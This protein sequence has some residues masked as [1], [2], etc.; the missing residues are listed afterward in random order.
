MTDKRAVACNVNVKLLTL[1]LQ[2]YLADN[3]DVFPPG[4]RW[5][6]L[7]AGY[8]EGASRFTCPEAHNRVCSY[9]FNRALSG[10]A[11]PA[12]AD[13][14]EVIAIFES[15]AGWNAFGGPELL[16]SEPRHF[17]GEYVG[18]VSSAA[19]WKRRLRGR[20]QGRHG[21]W[22]KAYDPLLVWHPSPR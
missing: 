5:S 14:S 22:L 10:A 20:A 4:G 8:V 11:K 17:G 18:L 16:P 7:L 3:D 9:A 6:D 1:A 15:D 21:V 19:G 13:W 12:S 2:T